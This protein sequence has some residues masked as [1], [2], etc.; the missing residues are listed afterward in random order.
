MSSHTWIGL[1]FITGK[2][3]VQC[4]LILHPCYI[5]H[6]VIAIV[7]N[8]YIDINFIRKRTTLHTVSLTIHVYEVHF[9]SLKL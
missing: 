6:E 8:N 4:N 9:L 7:Y 5:P 2:L 3:I 1:Q